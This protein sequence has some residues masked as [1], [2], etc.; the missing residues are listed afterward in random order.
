MKKNIGLLLFIGLM[1]VKASAF[2][3]HTHYEEYGTALEDCSVCDL[4]LEFQSMDLE[5]PSQYEVPATLES[6]LGLSL[7][8]KKVLLFQDCS[9]K[10][11]VTRPPPIISV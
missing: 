8:Q 6:A 5:L 1:L 11:F 7:F 9:L 4:V 10:H 2:H 3:V